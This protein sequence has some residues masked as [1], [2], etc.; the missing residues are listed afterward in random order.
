MACHVIE[1]RDALLIRRVLENSRVT[2]SRAGGS[3]GASLTGCSY[4]LLTASSRT[5]RRRSFSGRQR[6][7][8]RPLIVDR[9]WRRGRGARNRCYLGS[10]R[11][12]REAGGHQ[13]D[14]DE[15]YSRKALGHLAPLSTRTLPSILTRIGVR[16]ASGIYQLH[17]VARKERTSTHPFYGVIGRPP[18]CNPDHLI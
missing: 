16:L 8:P 11:N 6:K 17:D 15:L 13:S 9:W 10:R 2:L 1:T 7:R 3:C 14:A 4:A 5:C 18:A 12:G